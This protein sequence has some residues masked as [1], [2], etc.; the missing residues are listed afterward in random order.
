MKKLLVFLFILFPFLAN[1]ATYNVTCSGNITSALNG[2]HTAAS[3]GDTI[4]VSSGSCTTSSTVYLSKGITLQ[5]AG[6]GNTVITGSVMP[7]FQYSSSN[8]A[9]NQNFRITGFSFNG[10]GI[11]SYT[12]SMYL[13]RLT[14]YTGYEQTNV[15]V[16]HNRF[17][18]ASSSNGSFIDVVGVWGVIDNNTFETSRIPI[19]FS[20][21]TSDANNY[22]G[23][24]YWT[25]FDDLSFGAA[26]N[27]MYIENNTFNGVQYQLSDSQGGNRYSYRYNT[28]TL[29]AYSDPIW[30]IHGNYSYTCTPTCQMF[31][32]YGGE[33]YGNQI[34]TSYGGQLVSVR[35]GK[36]LTFFNNVTSSASW[37][38]G[39]LRE[40]IRDSAAPL[41]NGRVQHANTTYTWG[42]KKNLTTAL[43]GLSVYE[44]CSTS[45]VSSTCSIHADCRYN[46]AGVSSLLHNVQY[47]N[48]ASGYDGT[49]GMGCGTLGNRPAT[50][51]EGTAYW[52]T[53]QSCSDL[54]NM[55]GKAPATPISGTL[56]ICGSNNWV[57]A[58]TYTPY[59]YPH[60]LTGS[61]GEGDTTDPSIS[62]QSPSQEQG[63]DDLDDT[64]DIT[65]SLSTNEASTC[66]WDTVT[67][68]YADLTNT[69]TGSGTTSHTA[70]ATLACGTTHSIYYACQD[71][72]ENTT[73][74]AS[75]SFSIAAREDTTTPVIT[76]ATSAKQAVALTQKLSITTQIG[77][78]CRY[79]TDGVDGC[80]S[81]TA[82]ADRTAFS[83]TGGELT[84]HEVAITQAAS[85]S[86]TY[87]VICQNTQGTATSANSAITITTDAAKAITAGAGSLSITQGSGSLSVTILP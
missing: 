77:A 84:H 54:T 45:C 15:R 85:S 32:A 70:T 51:T 42:N 78:S 73:D 29:T 44:N 71:T 41:V 33:F 72:A 57:D 2:A 67:H 8:P 12:N 18:G 30:D 13:L 76:S 82:W 74:T 17:Y 1:A 62:A 38:S 25:D 68:A 49:S 55:V 75:W 60:P 39:K 4:L 48:Y 50:C 10:N 53:T 80:S 34:T 22:K 56:Y 21:Y 20:G 11:A 31:S 63:C 59:T 16:D 9:A 5:G 64:E 69:F 27:T 66:K 36:A 61:G 40:E 26:A 83:V 79:C 86:A 87:N 14:N 28:I 47:W 37:V 81:A 19:R 23:Y 52:A 7:M 3:T 65:I 43:S 35:G 58:T 6:I 46:G 24:T